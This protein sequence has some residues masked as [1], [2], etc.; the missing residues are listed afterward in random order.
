M[1]AP[2]W[3]SLRPRP[4]VWAANFPWVLGAGRPARSNADGYGPDGSVQRWGVGHHH[5]HHGLGVEGAA[6]RRPPGA[7]A[8]AA[9]VPELRPEFR[10]RRYLLEQSPSHAAGDPEGKRLE[11]VGQFAPPVLVIAHPL[12][13]PLDG[14]EQFPAGTDRSLRRDSGDRGDRLLDLAAGNH[15]GAGGDLAP[16]SRRWQGPQRPALPRALFDPNPAR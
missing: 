2:L 13:H 10:L 7:V 14:R 11:L 5:H 16:R 1:L 8:A 15:R 4:R 9:G 3:P 6:W 12:R